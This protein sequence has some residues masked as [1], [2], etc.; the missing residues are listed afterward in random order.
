MKAVI[1]CAG[2]GKRM[3]PLTY[4]FPKHL[5]PIANKPVLFYGLESISRCGIK[6]VG[7]VINDME[8]EIVKRV[9]KGEKFGVNIEYIIQSNPKGLAH[10]VWCARDFVGEDN[11]VVYLGDNFIREELK[12]FVDIFYKERANA[13]VLLT[14][15]DDPTHFGVAVVSEGVVKQVLEK[16]KNPPS[17]LILVGVYI[18][19]SNIFEAIEHI[20]PSY[21]G[22]LEITDAIQYLI[23]KGYKIVP[24]IIKGWWKD[25]GRPEDLLEA[26]RVVMEYS[27]NRNIEGEIISSVV[28]GRVVIGKGSKIIRSKIRGP[29]VIGENSIIEN[30]F[31]GPFTSIGDN[32]AVRNSEVEYSVIMENTRVLDIEGRVEESV[33]GRHAYL[34]K[35]HRRPKVYKFILGDHTQA[36][37]I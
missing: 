34:K 30:S 6:E 28:V 35:E 12:N 25:T 23:D 21:R 31:I 13:V 32:V 1:L 27:I 11:F 16:P 4:S 29:V 3:R 37:L 5:L 17:N 15:V 10:A 19:D 7:I 26:N 20:K 24:Y 8:S 33:I 9:N 2:K 22:E 14:E 36:V 18:F